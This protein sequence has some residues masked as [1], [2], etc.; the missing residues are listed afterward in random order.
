MDKREGKQVDPAAEE[1]KE[2]GMVA[3]AVFLGGGGTT[4][5][6]SKFGAVASKAVQVR[7]LKLSGHGTTM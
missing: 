1:G 6:H 4:P 5:G 2:E 7:A 3:A